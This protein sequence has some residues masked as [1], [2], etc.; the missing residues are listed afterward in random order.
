LLHQGEDALGYIISGLVWILVRH[1]RDLVVVE[2]AES[3]QRSLVL[4]L[5]WSLVAIRRRR[6]RVD[7]ALKHQ[8]KTVPLRQEEYLL[9]H[10]DQN[11]NFTLH[12]DKKFIALRVVLKNNVTRF[13]F[14]DGEPLQK[15][16]DGLLVFDVLEEVVEVWQLLVVALFH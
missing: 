7:L 11:F 16:I 10:W 14:A 4:L 9:D 3:Q 8:A 2:D 15:E 12:D 5:A 13:D 1:P 6:Q